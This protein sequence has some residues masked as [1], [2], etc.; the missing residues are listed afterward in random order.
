MFF[1]SYIVR[2]ASLSRRQRRQKYAKLR[3]YEIV[4][5][6]PVDSSAWGTGGAFNAL[7][8]S[9]HKVWHSTTK[10]ASNDKLKLR[11]DGVPVGKA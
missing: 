6:Q 9:F 10:A 2:Q 7:G 5:E 8:V 11:R 4:Q 3:G 1:M